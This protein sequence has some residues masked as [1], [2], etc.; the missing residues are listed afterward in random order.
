MIPE[1]RVDMPVEAFNKMEDIPDKGEMLRV[2]LKRTWLLKI[3]PLFAYM[4]IWFPVAWN[5]LMV[6]EPF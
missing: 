1:L 4:R 5:V 3:A 6:T 2:L